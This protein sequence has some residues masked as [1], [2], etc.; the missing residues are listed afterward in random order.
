MH[1]SGMLQ[2]C[3]SLLLSFPLIILLSVS[4]LLYLLFPVACRCWLTEH[5][6]FLLSSCHRFSTSVTSRRRN[7]PLFSSS[8]FPEAIHFSGLFLNKLVHFSLTVDVQTRHKQI[9]VSPVS[10]MNCLFTLIHFWSIIYFVTC[11]LDSLFLV[12]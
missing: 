5:P 4:S 2:R 3:T 8:V 9:Y 7:T 11:E 1:H 12:L 10:K 6:P